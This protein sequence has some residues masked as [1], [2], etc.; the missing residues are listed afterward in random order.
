[1]PPLSAPAHVHCCA[2]PRAPPLLLGAALARPLLH[3]VL[4]Q[5]LLVLRHLVSACA[6]LPVRA[7]RRCAAASARSDIVLLAAPTRHARVPL[8]E[9]T[10]CYLQCTT[11]Y[12]EKGQ[13]Q[14]HLEFQTEIT[15]K[16]S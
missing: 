11:G 10:C 5:P 2:A 3:A 8:S 13:E 6:R 4:A 7:G 9:L 15:L 14:E 1:M 16:T 12:R